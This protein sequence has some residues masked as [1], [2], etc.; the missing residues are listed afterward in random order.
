MWRLAEALHV[1]KY[2]RIVLETLRKPI[3]PA[4]EKFLHP[5]Q[6]FLGLC[7]CTTVL[8]TL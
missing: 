6:E 2:Q 4:E 5:L 1:A 8:G 3:Q 7:V